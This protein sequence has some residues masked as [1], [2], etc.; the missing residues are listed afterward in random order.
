[1]TFDAASYFDL[2]R[3]IPNGYYLRAL[4]NSVIG[5]SN[6]LISTLVLML[7]RQKSLLH[8]MAAAGR[9]VHRT[10]LTKWSFLL[11]HGFPSRGGSAFYDFLP[12]RFGPF[13]FCLYQEADKL[14][15]QGYIV[16]RGEHAWELTGLKHPAPEQPVS[17]DI[18]AL[19]GEFL[20]TPLDGLVEYVYQKFPAFTVHSERKK[21]A[22]RPRACPAVYTA[23]YEGESVDAFLNKLIVAGIERILDVRSNPIARRYGF[24]KSTLSRLAQKVQID[25]VH[26]PE[27]GIKSELRRGLHENENYVELF[28]LYCATTLRSERAAIERVASRVQ[29]KPSVLVCMEADPVCC[30]RSHL[31]KRVATFCKLPVVHIASSQ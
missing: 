8:L 13:S 23:G 31:A 30:H 12:Y 28:S 27:L 21:L 24:H 14:E 6:T 19:V 10:E 29:E 2:G 9:P 5:N 25:Y 3:S 22:K 4:R 15:Q 20:A 18:D 16:Q 1:M 26:L 17:R 7:T 11:R